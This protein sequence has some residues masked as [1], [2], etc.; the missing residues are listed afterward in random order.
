MLSDVNPN[1]ISDGKFAIFRTTKT[2]T[3]TNVK[4]DGDGDVFDEKSY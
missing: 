4:E 3:V 1:F 2:A